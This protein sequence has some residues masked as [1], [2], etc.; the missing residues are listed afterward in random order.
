MSRHAHVA[1]P[2]SLHNP[3]LA[4]DDSRL[5]MLRGRRPRIAALSGATVAVLCSAA[6]GGRVPRV[7][8][9]PTVATREWVDAVAMFFVFADP[10]LVEG[11]LAEPETFD[12]LDAA[13][14]VHIDAVLG[15][16]APW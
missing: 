11:S 2:V 6:Q 15:E 4:E 12:R 13:L 3:T 9:T 10:D 8:T 14:S 16:V 5:V 1:L 7:F